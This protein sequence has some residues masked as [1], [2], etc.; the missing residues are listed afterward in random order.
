MHRTP[1]PALPH[2][3]LAATVLIAAV[4]FRSW[5]FLHYDESYFDSDQAIVGLMAKHLAEGRAKPLFFYGQE[6]MLAVEAWVM[7]PVFALLGPTVLALRLT[8]ILLNVAGALA[9]WWLLMRESALPPW[10]AALAA[11]PFAMAP[12]ITAA[13]LVEAQGGNVE[14]FLW[15]LVLWLLR[16]RPA[17]LGI[18]LGLAFLNREFTIYAVPALLA[19]E[20]VRARGRFVPLV[21][22]WLITLVSFVLVLVTVTAS[23]PR[24]SGWYFACPPKCHLPTRAVAYPAACRRWA[25]VTSEEGRPTSGS[26]L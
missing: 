23:K 19:V 14:P 20:L 26:S 1:H 18:A 4:V 6:Y 24:R 3:A 21:R 15:V 13:H 7:A 17:L 8:M 2:V 22:P 16:A 11:A 9:L 10:L 12:F 25:S 5:F